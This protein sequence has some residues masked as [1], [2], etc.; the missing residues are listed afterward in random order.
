MVLTVFLIGSFSNSFAQIDSVNVVEN[1]LV[2][3]IGEG[4]DADEESLKFRWVQIGGDPVK[5]SSYTD[6]M[7]TFMAP[8][9]SNGEIKVLTF[10]LTITD[11]LGASNS[12]VVEVVVNPVNHPPVVDA[13]RD[14]LALPTINAMTLI[15]TVSD[16][17]GDVLS[18]SWKQLSGQQLELSNPAQKHLTL[19]PIYFDFSQLDPLTFELTVSDGF[20]GIASDTVNVF[21]FTGLL[22]NKRIS[23]Q[24]GSMQTVTEGDVVTLSATGQTLDGKSISYS[25]VQLIGPRVSLNAYNEQ[26]VQFTAPEI[27]DVEKLLSFQVTGYSQG[28]GWANALALVKVLPSNGSPI[29]D[30]GP[31]Q[32]VFGNTLVKLVGTGTDPDGERLK[33]SW[34]Q[35][36]GTSVPFYE[37]TPFSI[38]FTTPTVS[39]P[40]QL[41]FEFTVT[42]PH[43][44][45]D[46]DEVIVTVTDVNSPPRA[47]AGNDKRVVSGSQVEIV[48]SGSDVDGDPLTYKWRQVY[49][50]FVKFTDSA[51][52]FTFTAPEVTGSP[53]RL[54]FQLMVTDTEGQSA[55]DNVVVF[56]VPENGAPIA[57][58]GADMRVNENTSVNIMCS[59]QDPDHDIISFS[60]ESESDIEI[61]Q[62]KNPKTSVVTPNVVKDTPITLTCTVSDGTLFSSDSMVLTV[63]NTLNLDI[64]A[65]AGPDKI[66]NE[67]VKVSLDGSGSYDPEK[68]IL[69][70]QWTQTSGE[71]VSLS[72]A[73]AKSPSFTSPTVANN[74]IKV[75]TFELKVFDEHGRSDVDSVT[76][77]VDPINSPPEASASAMQ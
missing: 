9:V 24:T 54:E 65:N 77:T 60:W 41:V 7:P 14:R 5:L 75:L 42:D 29:A 39:S 52:S 15:P 21:P 62:S 50:S 72:S 23:V 48:G 71:K 27:G 51:S 73:T 45:Y 34:A 67:N 58:A 44:N 61:A 22:D 36:S 40:E 11:P 76:I 35:K 10:E 57:N 2:T 53:V 68:Q 63:V 56:V 18:Y 31:D 12:D 17:D 3:L 46:T 30:A 33:S 28:N 69:S 32:N 66:V 26:Q 47:F 38:Y 4:Y 1:K 37:R 74:E 64:V 55:K 43:G 49:G 20:G 70:Y 59:G 6:P 16:T 19:Q 13:G 8:N 25:W